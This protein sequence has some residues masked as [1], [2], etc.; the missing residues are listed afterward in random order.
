MSW[1]AL[2]VYC[3]DTNMRM[4]QVQLVHGEWRFMK[5]DIFIERSKKS[6]VSEHD[7]IKQWM[8]LFDEQQCHRRL[9]NED[10]VGDPKRRM[11]IL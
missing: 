10:G 8:I 3:A 4:I 6:N 1:W 9:R 7:G 2:P 11:K 5:H